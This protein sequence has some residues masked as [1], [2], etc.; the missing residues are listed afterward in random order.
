[1]LNDLSSACA[2]ALDAQRAFLAETSHELRTPLTS[3]QGFLERA[4][5]ARPIPRSGATSTT[6][7]ASPPGMSRLVG[8]LLQLSRGE[9]V[10]EV[11]P[12]LVD[13]VADVL[14]PVAEE[15]PGVRGRGGGRRHGAGRPGAAAPAGAQPGGQRGARGR[16][17]RA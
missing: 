6:P 2:S 9:V 17:G 7:S 3:L 13:P 16:A 8:D 15:F 14:R 1:V 5:R 11:D 10:R 12:F 4:S